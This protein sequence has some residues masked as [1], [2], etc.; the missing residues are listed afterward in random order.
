VIKL[1]NMLP[2]GGE[3]TRVMFQ[4]ISQCPDYLNAIP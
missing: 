2:F 3:S 4:Y 1:I